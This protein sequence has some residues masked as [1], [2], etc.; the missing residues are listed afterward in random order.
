MVPVQMVAPSKAQ[1]SPTPIWPP[2]KS[3]RWMSTSAGVLTAMSMASSLMTFCEMMV[4]I[5]GDPPSPLLMLI[6]TG[7][8]VAVS[9]VSARFPAITL[10][11]ILFA[12]MSSAGRPNAGPTCVWRA[13]PPQAIVGQCIPTDHITGDTTLAG[14][15]GKHARSRSS[16]LH[17]VTGRKVLGHGILVHS[18][19]GSEWRR[20]V[21]RVGMRSKDDAA[22][23]RI[24]LGC[25]SDEQVVAAFCGFVAD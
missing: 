12:D 4:P 23:L 1:T 11:M 6:P 10:P 15:I 2:R 21:T 5:T 3:L 17:A 13:T 24:V 25:V 20:S 8:G 14:A 18:K 7:P 16:N 9:A 22:L 19:V